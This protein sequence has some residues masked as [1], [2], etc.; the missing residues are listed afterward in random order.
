[1]AVS[2]LYVYIQCISKSVRIASSF[3]FTKQ[4]CYTR[5][6]R[7][8]YSIFVHHE[9]SKLDPDSD[10]NSYILCGKNYLKSLKQLAEKYPGTQRQQAKIIGTQREYQIL[11]EQRQR[12][13]DCLR[14]WLSRLSSKESSSFVAS[15]KGKRQIVVDNFSLEF[16]EYLINLNLCTRKPFI[17]IFLADFPVTTSIWKRM[18]K[19]QGKKN[20]L[21]KSFVC[22]TGKCDVENTIGRMDRNIRNSFVPKKPFVEHSEEMHKENELNETKK[23]GTDIGTREFYEALFESMTFHPKGI[24][25]SYRLQETLECLLQPSFESPAFIYFGDTGYD[26]ELFKDSLESC[27]QQLSRYVELYYR[28]CFLEVGMLEQSN[29]QRLFPFYRKSL[30]ISACTSSESAKVAM[31]RFSESGRRIFYLYHKQFPTYPLAFAD[32]ALTSDIPRSMQELVNLELNWNEMIKN[33]ERKPFCI[34]MLECL[35]SSEKHIRAG[36]HQSL[37]TLLLYDYLP[38]TFG[39]F[40][41]RVYSLSHISGFLSWLYFQYE[42][43][44]GLRP[45]YRSVIPQDSVHLIGKVIHD[46]QS[47]NN[48]EKDIDRQLLDKAKNVILSLCAYYLLMVRRRDGLPVDPNC[49]F[50]VTNGAEVHQLLWAADEGMKTWKE[51]AHIMSMYCYR[52]EQLSTT[53]Y[54]FASTCKV[55]TSNGMEELLESITSTG[56]DALDK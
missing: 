19:K 39:N 18:Q 16:A 17:T 38:R 14:K 56:N 48:Q 32:V 6:F 51:S 28:R 37:L 21:C 1:M 46:I 47:H 23:L 4:S 2:N 10:I 49:A 7:S 35:P 12:Q 44:R 24:V 40:G 53:A 8:N 3:F 26:W 30:E 20:D 55:T 15:R 43:A 27:L 13:V 5:P 11:C 54:E 29:F 42:I 36:F 9:R 31:E 33:A 52:L 22:S 34:V 50:H 25:A 45:Q 41:G